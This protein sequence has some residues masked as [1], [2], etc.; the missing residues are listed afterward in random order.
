MDTL[1]SYA[2]SLQNTC[3]SNCYFV[4]YMPH[5]SFVQGGYGAQ[6]C[7]ATTAGYATSAGSPLKPEMH[8]F[9]V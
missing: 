7:D 8:N 2:N 9:V 4:Y 1:F 5:L 6:V 3:Y